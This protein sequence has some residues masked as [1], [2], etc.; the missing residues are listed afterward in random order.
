MADETG[1]LLI[2]IL[3]LAVAGALIGGLYYAAAELPLEKT[4]GDQPPENSVSSTV[5]CDICRDNC[6]YA[7]DKYECLSGCD[8]VC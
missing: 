8:L 5:Q 4:S 3:V 6:E 1:K 2:F 7:D